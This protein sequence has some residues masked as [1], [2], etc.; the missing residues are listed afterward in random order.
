MKCD[1]TNDIQFIGEK[2]RQVAWN[3]KLEGFVCEDCW[4][5]ISDATDF[6][7][8]ASD[9]IELVE[10]YEEFISSLETEERG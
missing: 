6:W 7:K 9:E 10:S 4:S 3:Q 5:A 1:Y 2:K 8:D